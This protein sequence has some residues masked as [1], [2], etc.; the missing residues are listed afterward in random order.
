[1]E[2]KD[3]KYLRTPLLCAAKS[4]HPGVVQALLDKGADTKVK[5]KSNQT[6]LSLI[7][8]KKGFEVIAK[9]L[10]DKS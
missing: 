9:L 7:A 8:G 6:A 3:T 5:D 2:V 10:E 1:M 4:G